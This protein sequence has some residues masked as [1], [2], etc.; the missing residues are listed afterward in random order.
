MP[1]KIVTAVD[2]TARDGGGGREQ[3]QGIPW[4][5]DGT[6]LTVAAGRDGNYVVKIAPWSRS[7]PSTNSP[8]R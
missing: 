7:V 3:N 6:V 5:F 4:P 8:Y 2:T 1:R